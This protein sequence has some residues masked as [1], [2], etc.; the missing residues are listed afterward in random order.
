MTQFES[1]E[2]ITSINIL[3]CF[4]CWRV[5]SFVFVQR[6]IFHCVR[7]WCVAWERH[8][9]LDITTVRKGCKTTLQRVN[10]HCAWTKKLH[11]NTPKTTA[12]EQLAH[13]FW[14]CV[15]GNN[16]P[17]QPVAVVCICHLKRETG[18]ARTVVIRSACISF[19]P[20]NFVVWLLSSLLFFFC[21]LV[22]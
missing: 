21:S 8:G 2:F 15:R 1:W 22:H 19:C 3:L 10:W 18:I 11:L 14:T 5:V 9:L 13:T 17:Y 7:T 6:C 16:S 4:V 12:N 20:L